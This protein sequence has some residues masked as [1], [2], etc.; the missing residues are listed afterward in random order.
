MKLQ[1]KEN[2]TIY[3]ED[4]ASTFSRQNNN[5]VC[6]SRFRLLTSTVFL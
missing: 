3:G 1:E 4:I 6:L 2:Q 5:K